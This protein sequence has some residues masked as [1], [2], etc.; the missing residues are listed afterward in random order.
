MKEQKETRKGVREE[1]RNKRKMILKNSKRG[2]AVMNRKSRSCLLKGR[3]TSSGWETGL[4]VA[5]RYKVG[6]GLE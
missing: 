2:P 6:K 3:Q 1:N 5:H 4:A